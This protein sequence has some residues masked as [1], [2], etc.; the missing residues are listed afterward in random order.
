MNTLYYGIFWVWPAMDE[1][2]GGKLIC[3]C[4]TV[5]VH[6]LVVDVS[7]VVIICNPSVFG[8]SVSFLAVILLVLT[9][10][11][12]IPLFLSVFIYLKLNKNLRVKTKMEQ[13]KPTVQHN[14]TTNPVR[15]QQEAPQITEAPGANPPSPIV[16]ARYSH[17]SV[18][19]AS[20]GLLDTIWENT[21]E[22]TEVE[23]QIMDIHNRRNIHIEEL[24]RPMPTY[25]EMDQNG[26]PSYKEEEDMYLPSYSELGTK[27]L[28][29][30][31][32]LIVVDKNF[33]VFTFN[34]NSYV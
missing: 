33:H 29:I 7:S 30:G 32:K 9:P 17:S 18:Q 19:G 20:D 12:L 11:L 1:R 2:N 34:S 16:Q 3:W 13:I 26:L 31:T 15:I 6:V 28:H 4:M 24:E 8:E 25:S 21:S 23:N 5:F 22:I 14:I 10:F 27:S